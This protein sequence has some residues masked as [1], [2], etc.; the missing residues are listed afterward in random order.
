MC[1]IPLCPAAPLDHV[2]VVS[3]KP[4]AYTNS[5]RKRSLLVKCPAAEVYHGTIY[6][7]TLSNGE[8]YIG[9][10]RQTKEQRLAGHKA[11]PTNEKMAQWMDDAA[12]IETLEDFV[13]TEQATLDRMEREWIEREAA[14]GVSLTNVQHNRPKP[15]KEPEAAASHRRVITV[16]EDEK[17]QRFEVRLRKNGV[18]EEDQVR[19]FP[20]GADKDA[21][22]EEACVHRE[23]LMKKYF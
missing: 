7:I 21:A 23:Q 16:H 20:W 17:K 18:A 5:T 9:Q 10:T 4:T 19:R 15:V 11:K 3:K 13:F 22:Y 6:R 8:Q 12:R 1:S 2:H 14:R